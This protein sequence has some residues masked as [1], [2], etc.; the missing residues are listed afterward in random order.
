LPIERGRA[1]RV[2]SYSLK[3]I[4][5]R[6]KDLNRDV[7]WITTHHSL[8]RYRLAYLNDGP[9]LVREMDEPDRVRGGKWN[10]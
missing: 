8:T 3:E 1:D 5:A 6:A 2:P 9:A 10:D 7:F 4:H